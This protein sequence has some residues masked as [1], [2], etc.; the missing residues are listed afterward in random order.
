MRFA[1]RFMQAAVDA[2]T[3]IGRS[4]RTAIDPS[5]IR[6]LAS[7]RPAVKAAESIAPKVAKASSAIEVVLPKVE[8]AVAGTVASTVTRAAPQPRVLFPGLEDGR[9]DTPFNCR[10]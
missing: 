5:T 8:E 3:A 10:S 6:R 9:R 1:G 2:G 7:A 4:R